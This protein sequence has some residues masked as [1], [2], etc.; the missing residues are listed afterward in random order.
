MARRLTW[1]KPLVAIIGVVFLAL[2][3]TSIFKLG[4]IET[5]A[6]LIPSVLGVF[7]ATLF[8]ILV[9]AFTVIPQKPTGDEKFFARIKMR[10]RRGAY[11][12]LGVVFLV[13][14]FTVAALSLRLFGVW[15]GEI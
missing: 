1:S 11:H 7:W 3:L 2:F 10:I 6:Y 13:L 14:T 8:F 12:L 4:G 5:D 9:S 15:F